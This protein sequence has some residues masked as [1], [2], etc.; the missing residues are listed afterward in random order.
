MATKRTLQRIKKLGDLTMQIVD[1]KRKLDKIDFFEDLD[2]WDVTG[3]YYNCKI[4]NGV[5]YSDKGE[6]LSNY[7]EC[8]DEEIPYFVNQNTGYICDNYYGTMY[9]RVADLNT[10]VAIEYSC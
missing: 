9:V 4:K 1:I 8:M 10:F 7:G 2:S 6:L 5:L 3:I